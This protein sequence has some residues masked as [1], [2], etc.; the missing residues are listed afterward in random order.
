MI[1]SGFDGDSGNFTLQADVIPA[2][3]IFDQGD[4]ICGLSSISSDTID[5]STN[6]TK[7]AVIGSLIDAPLF[8]L[9]MSIL[10]DTENVCDS[11][12]Y[13]VYKLILSD[14]DGDNIVYNVEFNVDATYSMP[15]FS[16]VKVN[17]SNDEQFID[18][19]NVLCINSIA[20]N[21]L[22][23]ETSDQI[24]HF[25]SGGTWYV[26]VTFYGVLECD[27]LCS[28][29][30]CLC[31]VAGCGVRYFQAEISL[32]VSSTLPNLVDPCSLHVD[33]QA[34]T[35]PFVTFNQSQYDSVSSLDSSCLPYISG[36]PFV[37]SLPIS[38]VGSIQDNSEM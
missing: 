28:K 36:Y 9:P 19:T 1:I 22:Y 34:A 16:I 11:T 6:I 38:L 29:G 5:L 24:V 18:V 37:I 27:A 31:S 4:R 13:L 25:P 2:R 33:I 17:C 26:I 7:K 32:S 15:A 30:A 12:P 20:A 35:L 21:S 3:V 8:D 14:N 23:E 10:C